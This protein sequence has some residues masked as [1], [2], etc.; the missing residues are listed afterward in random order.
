MNTDKKYV[1][2]ISAED[3]INA[4]LLENHIAFLYGDIDEDTVMNI[5]YWIT[6]ENLKPGNQP[7]TLYINS[8]G[9]S[10]QDAFALI[11][12]M[13]K[14]KRKIRTVGIGSVMSAGFLIF[15]SGTKGERYITKTASILCHQLS[16][17]I[18]GKHHDIN[19]Y[20][21]ENERNNQNMIEILSESCELDKNEIKKILLPPTDVWLTANEMIQFKLADKYYED[22]K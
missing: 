5:I 13:K 2:F 9:G 17:E 15:V 21:K 18:E 8:N 4:G 11:E 1:E 20:Y 7:L 16:T 12:V 22:L 19:S 3:R 14:S 10:L 6:Y